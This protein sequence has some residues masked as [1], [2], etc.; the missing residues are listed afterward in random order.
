MDELCGVCGQ[1]HPH[2]TGELCPA[3]KGVPLR[4]YGG[5]LEARAALRA[6]VPAAATRELRKRENLLFNIP[7]TI[8]QLFGSLIFPNYFIH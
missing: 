2:E 3:I 6:N 7:L 1:S 8:I 4:V 5:Y